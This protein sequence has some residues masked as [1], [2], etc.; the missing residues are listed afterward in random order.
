MKKNILILRHKG[1]SV[2]ILVFS[3]FAIMGLAS[4]VVD[5]GLMLNQRYELQKAVESAALLSA[6]EYEIYE[7]D[8]GGGNMN[9]AIPASTEIT[10]A[11]TG[12]A[13]THYKALKE[14]NQLINAGSGTDVTPTVTFNAQSGAVRVEADAAAPTYFI[15]ILGIKEIKLQGKAAA[16]NKPIYLSKTFPKPTGS[17]LNGVNDVTVA[18]ADYEDTDIKD[19]L[20]G[21]T[22]TGIHP[23]GSIFNQNNDLKNIYGQ[24]DQKVLSLG[25]GG[26]ITIKLPA[27]IYDGKGIDFVIYERGHAEG[28]FV[29]AGVD[30]DPTVPYIDAANPGSG[31]KWINVSCAGIPLYAK[32]DEVIGSHLTTI[33][34][35]GVNSQNYKFYGSGF[36]DL[37]VKCDAVGLGTIYDG[38]GATAAPR[39][40]NAKYLKIIDD[41]M[42]DGFFLQPKYGN[43][44]P[45][46]IPTL[47]PGEHSGFSP[48]A[49]IDAI[50]ILHHSRLISLA[51]FVGGDT[52]G[53]GLMNITEQMHGY[54]PG[55]VDTD[56]DGINDLKEYRGYDPDDTDIL[57]NSGPS[58]VLF[59]D[60]VNKDVPPIVIEIKP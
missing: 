51:D 25:P 37:G 24:P 12:N 31:I 48:G 50:A 2:I 35:N 19:P 41:N 26:H 38:T 47:L 23:T 30:A 18:G 34:I 49:D 8:A 14:T 54:D 32:I 28:Y 9:L 46:A 6:S 57:L 52:D 36:F 10:D 39:I 17:I 60:S 13:S 45:S 53:D 4:F 59:K 7:F 44:Q 1:A 11:T 29:Y 21:D 20:G 16:I 55:N 40:K 43:N 22:S 27:T 56:G 15:S 3:L 58:K 33:E 5:L 42:E